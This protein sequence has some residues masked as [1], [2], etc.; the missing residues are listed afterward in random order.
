M[1]CLIV[2]LLLIGGGVAFVFLYN[3]GEL[4]VKLKN[5]LGI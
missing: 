1:I 4:W 5:W 2:T 3:D